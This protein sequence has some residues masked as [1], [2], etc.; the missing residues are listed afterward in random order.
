MIE[1]EEFRPRRK[2]DPMREKTDAERKEASE[3]LAYLESLPW[4][5]FGI[6]W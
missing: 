4:Q 2:E 1:E 6:D 5:P 3:T